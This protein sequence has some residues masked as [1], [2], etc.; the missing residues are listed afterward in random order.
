MEL[1]SHPGQGLAEVSGRRFTSHPANDPQVGLKLQNSL[2]AQRDEHD[3]VN[4]KAHLV[5]RFS[6]LG[7][8]APQ[9]GQKPRA[10]RV[11]CLGETSTSPVALLCHLTLPKR[12]FWFQQIRHSNT[13]LTVS[14]FMG[15]QYDVFLQPLATEITAQ[16]PRHKWASIST[17]GKTKILKVNNK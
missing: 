14:G 7:V 16:R 15:R 8:S 11:K 2:H 6:L 1:L 17:K 5:F 13:V 9:E 10:P 4:P 3:Q 12:R